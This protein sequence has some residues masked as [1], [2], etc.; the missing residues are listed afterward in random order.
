MGLIVNI[1]DACDVEA[2]ESLFM[3]CNK[4]CTNP[5]TNEKRFQSKGDSERE[6]KSEREVA[7]ALF[8]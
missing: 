7:E 1:Y 2:V 5:W 4:R 3:L 8:E 6:N